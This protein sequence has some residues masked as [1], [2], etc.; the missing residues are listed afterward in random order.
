MREVRFIGWT[1]DCADKILEGTI[2]KEE[3]EDENGPKGMFPFYLPI[4]TYFKCYMLYLNLIV[5]ICNICFNI[6]IRN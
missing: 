4:V 2:E 5:L 6:V 3:T 1:A